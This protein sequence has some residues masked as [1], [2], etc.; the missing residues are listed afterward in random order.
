M[1]KVIIYLGLCENDVKCCDLYLSLEFDI[2]SCNFS[3]MEHRSASFV[4]LEDFLSLHSNVW[5]RFKRCLMFELNHFGR[6]CEEYL[7]QGMS[8]SQ[9][10][11]ILFLETGQNL[12]NVTIT[13]REKTLVYKLTVHIDIITVSESK[14]LFQVSFAS[15][16]A[17]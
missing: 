9:A 11:K 15:R 4:V 13:R 12:L 8:S 2:S 17:V 16:M 14:F 3:S 7:A 1:T 10:L 5:T 6:L